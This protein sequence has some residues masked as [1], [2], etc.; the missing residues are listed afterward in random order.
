MS[1]YFPSAEVVVEARRQLA[2]GHYADV[3]SLMRLDELDEP[4]DGA[5]DEV[6]AEFVDLAREIGLESPEDG[7][8]VVL[9]PVSVNGVSHTTPVLVDMHYRELSFTSH[10]E[11]GAGAIPD[12]VLVENPR[13]LHVVRAELL[14]VIA[15]WHNS[16]IAE[17]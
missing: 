8:F 6:L 9:V 10:P 15:T 7:G 13:L 3:D 12:E 5:L 11:L 4:Y 1:R 14:G 17:E 2:T 16:E